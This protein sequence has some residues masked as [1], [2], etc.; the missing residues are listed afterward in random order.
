MIEIVR[1]VYNIPELRKRIVFT[2]LMLVVYRVGA[3]IPVPLIDSA[4]M[5]EFWASAT[6][7]YLPDDRGWG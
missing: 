1:N 2:F 5:Q 3:H 6:G 4:A 7:G